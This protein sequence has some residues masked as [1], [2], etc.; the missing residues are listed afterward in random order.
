MGEILLR[1]AGYVAVIVLGYLLRRFGVLRAEDFRV[2]ST[3][4]MKVTLPAAVIINF[5]GKEMDISLLFVTALALIFGCLC[6][7]LGY[8]LN[9]RGTKE[10]QAFCVLNYSGYNIGN[11][12]MPFVQSFLGSTG[13]IVTGLFDVGNVV[14]C[15]GGAAAVA[16]V[17]RRG[18]RLSLKKVAVS[19]S[20][21]VCFLTY[22][23]MTVLTFCGIT[24]PATL[25]DWV[26]I[27][28]N[29]NVF[30]SMLMI[31]VGFSGVQSAGQWK[32]IRR[33]LVGRYGLAAILALVCWFVLPFD[34]EIRR[35]LVV[36]VFAPLAS[37]N[38]PFT[39]EMEGDVGLASAMSSVSILVSI[40]CMVTLL[41]FLA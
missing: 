3:L 35:V 40:V 2:I 23:V 37:A 10:E 13:V 17:L 29:A 8:L 19:M 14:V 1:T 41:T 27:P 6:M 21:S 5:S 39:R 9:R 11:F 18:S 15:L 7:A 30:L 26:A 32:T 36:L 20:R 38:L 24:L 25:L 12:T 33:F 22:V 31:G 4:V 16:D 28:A 34:A